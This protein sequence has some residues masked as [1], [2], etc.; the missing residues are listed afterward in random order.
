M[1][2]GDDDLYNAVEDV[3]IVN[4]QLLPNIIGMNKIRKFGHYDF[5]GSKYAFDKIY[6]KILRSLNKYNKK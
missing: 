3:E 6:V 2:Y 5:I 4:T 1:H